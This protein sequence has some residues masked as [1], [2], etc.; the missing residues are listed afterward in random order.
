MGNRPGVGGGLEVSKFVV[1]GDVCIDWLAFT[2][3]AAD[4][5]EVDG[6]MPLNWELYTSTRMIA[7]RGGALLLSRMVKEASG[8]GVVSH[9]LD[10]LEVI[11]PE[12]VI[13]SFIELGRFPYSADEKDEKNLVDTYPAGTRTGFA[14]AGTTPPPGVRFF[15]APPSK[16]IGSFRSLSA[17]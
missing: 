1:A 7:C 9:R 15:R 2:V 14:P 13:H 17:S 4:L 5:V 8:A 11:P 10:D 3:P 12:E 16:G 6:R